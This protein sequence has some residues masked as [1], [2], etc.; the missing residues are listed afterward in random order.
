MTASGRQTQ[1]LQSSRRTKAKA[2]VLRADSR[3]DQKA[4]R[5]RIDL[6]PFAAQVHH[7]TLQ[8]PAKS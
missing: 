4:Q 3:A 2:L 8:T 6:L 1:I 5:L 7:Q